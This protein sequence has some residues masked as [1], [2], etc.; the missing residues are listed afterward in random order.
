M[1]FE[2]SLKGQVKGDLKDMKNHIQWKQAD[3]VSR[4]E[5]IEERVAVL[6]VLS[7]I[8]HIIERFCS[9]DTEVDLDEE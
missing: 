5:Y 8:N 2:K 7:R 3:I 4:G 6:T 9:N 1:I